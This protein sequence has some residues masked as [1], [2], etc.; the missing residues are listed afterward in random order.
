MGEKTI[1]SGRQGSVLFAYWISK[2]ECERRS[3]TDPMR[4]ASILT[5]TA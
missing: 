2:D 5:R 3:T 1:G 4:K